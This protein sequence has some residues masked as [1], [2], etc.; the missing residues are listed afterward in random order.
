V[1][2]QPLNYLFKSQV[3]NIHIHHSP[4]DNSIN[5]DLSV[6]KNIIIVLMSN[7]AHQHI[8]P[9]EKKDLSEKRCFNCNQKLC[10][11]NIIG[12]AV[13]IKCGRCGQMNYIIPLKKV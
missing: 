3:P 11:A 1:T 2:Q 8:P 9:T 5:I 4:V 13:E 10:N 7:R 6:Y 12:G